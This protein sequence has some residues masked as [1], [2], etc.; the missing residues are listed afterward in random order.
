[1][2]EPRVYRSQG[3]VTMREE[4]AFVH[5]IIKAPD[6]DGTRLVFADWLEERGEPERA[7]LIRVECQLERLLANSPNRYALEC[8]A[9]QLLRFSDGVFLFARHLSATLEARDR[10][11]LSAHG[12]Q[13]ARP[14]RALVDHFGFRRGFVEEVGIRGPAFLDAGEELFRLAPVRHVNFSDVPPVFVPTL[15]ACPHLGRLRSL[16]LARNRIG[17]RGARSLAESPH[18]AG[19]TT[20]D[21][22]H[23]RIGD[24]GLQALLVSPYLT[25]LAALYLRNNDLGPASVPLLLSSRL[26]YLNVSC[27]RF[28]E[29]DTRALQERFGDRVHFG[30]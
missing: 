15:A 24:A 19:L 16:R 28:N 9:R 8:R 22:A 3:E 30:L 4:D 27:N 29:Q 7:E 14:V 25:R 21:L 17:P 23:C 5:T 26:T 18:I 20:L 11:L 13:W 6:D 10:E 1:M 2:H 12:T